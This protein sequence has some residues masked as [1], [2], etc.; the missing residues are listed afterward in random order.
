[1]QEPHLPRHRP[2][3]A[4]NHAHATAAAAA[5]AEGSDGPKGLFHHRR[6]GR[7][8]LCVEGRRGRVVPE[9]PVA[10]SDASAASTA[11]S[12]ASSSPTPAPLQSGRRAER[13]P[14]GTNGRSMRYTK[15]CSSFG[16]SSW[17]ERPS[18]PPAETRGCPCCF[19][20]RRC[21]GGSPARPCARSTRARGVGRALGGAT[22]RRRS[23]PTC[24][25]LH[26]HHN[27]RRC[28]RRSKRSGRKRPPHPPTRT[29]LLGLPRRRQPPRPR[30]RRSG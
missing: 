12:A 9:E 30:P 28:R 26:H 25:C 19:P 6:L 17:T 8:Q 18:P 27:H 24:C 1:M 13:L 20:S 2:S 7:Q 16:P 10:A 15:C 29:R 14:R 4:A 22:G 3:V 5:A 11:S 21:C 23:P